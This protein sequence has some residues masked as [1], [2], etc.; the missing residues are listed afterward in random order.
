MCVSISPIRMEVIGNPDITKKMPTPTNPPSKC[1]RERVI[2]DDRKHCNGP[3][4]ID[5]GAVLVACV[6]RKR[7]GFQF[8]AAMNV[9]I[10]PPVSP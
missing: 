4:T 3:E 10:R 9:Y 5:I 6:W 2:G 7:K 1:Q 8:S